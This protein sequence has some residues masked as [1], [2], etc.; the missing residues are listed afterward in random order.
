MWNKT[1]HNKSKVEMLFST[2]FDTSFHKLN[3]VTRLVEKHRFTTQ[4]RENPKFY[5]KIRNFYFQSENLHQPVLI[6]PDR[7]T[8]IYYFWKPIQ[9]LPNAFQ[10]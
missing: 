6:L 3:N 5:I 4:R 10:L 8:L 2:G 7:N 1:T 9:K